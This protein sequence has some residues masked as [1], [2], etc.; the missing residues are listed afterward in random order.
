VK[1]VGLQIGDGAIVWFEK[2]PG[3]VPAKVAALL[4]P[5]TGAVGYLLVG[6][7]AGRDGEVIEGLR[8]TGYRTPDEPLTRAVRQAVCGR[9]RQA[10]PADE[11]SELVVALPFWFHEDAAVIEAAT[12]VG[13][14]SVRTVTDIYAL[15]CHYRELAR[16][17]GV[18]LTMVPGSELVDVG[19]WRW[20]GDTLLPLAWERW[21]AGEV[22]A[23]L[24][25]LLRA[26][27]C[28]P[29]VVV[30]GDLADNWLRQ[31]LA[32]QLQVAGCRWEGGGAAGVARAA[33]LTDVAPLGAGARLKVALQTR[34]GHLPLPGPGEQPAWRAL[35]THGAPVLLRLVGGWGAE[36]A[37]AIT[38]AEVLVQSPADPVLLRLAWDAETGTVTVCGPDHK[39]LAQSRFE[40]RRT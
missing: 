8:R 34:E 38:L 39:E 26:V 40:F 36:A 14:E 24:A 20:E 10:F 29:A 4:R 28:S 7:E 25:R 18:L 5:D 3:S 35:A 9:V 30:A 23:A 21:A 1:P 16:Q 17:H 27:G 37:P 22:P 32:E 15:A 11:G 33:A 2:A 6:D 19:A 13:W 31:G 12:A